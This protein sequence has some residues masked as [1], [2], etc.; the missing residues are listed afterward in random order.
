MPV[1][2]I[3]IGLGFMGGLWARSEADT[4]G[5]GT[6]AKLGRNVIW[7]G[8]VVSAVGVWAWMRKRS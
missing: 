3:W 1:F 8:A 6:G 7:A 5:E 4:D 2:L